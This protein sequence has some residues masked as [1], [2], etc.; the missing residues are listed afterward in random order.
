[1]NFEPQKFFIGL[2][3]FFSVLLPGALL[4]YATAGVLDTKVIS[5]LK[6]TG[7]AHAWIIFFISSYLLRHF[8][9][10]AGSWLD[11][12]YDRLRKVAPRMI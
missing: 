4:T 10:L 5:S 2:T 11:A 1:M 3:D 7:E 6:A 9:F 12:P 8:I